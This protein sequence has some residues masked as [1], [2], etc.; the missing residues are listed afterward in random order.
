MGAAFYPKKEKLPG[1]WKIVILTEQRPNSGI[2]KRL[3]ALI[4]VSAGLSIETIFS[5][6]ERK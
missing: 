4:L 6:S 1:L 2:V 5:Y 3:F